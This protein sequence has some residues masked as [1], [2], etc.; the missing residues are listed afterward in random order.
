MP[1]KKRLGSDPLSW[2][3]DTR[4][5]GD[6]SNQSKHSLQSIP[7]NSIRQKKTTQ[8]GLKEGWM[9]ATFIVRENHLE[10]VKALAYWDRKQ[11]KE[12]IDEAL[13]SYLKGKKTKPIKKR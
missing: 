4:T 1:K 12:V 10:K 13:T 11:L 3:Q 5:V 7:N 8:E 6:E 2:V 9:R